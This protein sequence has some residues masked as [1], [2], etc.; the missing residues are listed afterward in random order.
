MQYPVEVLFN[1][2]SQLSKARPLYILQRSGFIQ[3]ASTSYLLL[4]VFKI[5]LALSSVMKELLIDA[6]HKI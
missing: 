4:Y 1:S 2:V 6:I 3:I 5:I